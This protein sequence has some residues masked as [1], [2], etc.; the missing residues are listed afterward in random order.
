MMISLSGAGLRFFARR[1]IA[2]CW[3]RNNPDSGEAEA[4][5]MARVTLMEAEETFATVG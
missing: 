3:R 5:Y 1:Q 4:F 2:F